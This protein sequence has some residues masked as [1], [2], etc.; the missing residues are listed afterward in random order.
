MIIAMLQILRGAQQHTLTHIDA[1]VV[2]C[3]L[4]SV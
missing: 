3:V 1:S 2:A 4:A